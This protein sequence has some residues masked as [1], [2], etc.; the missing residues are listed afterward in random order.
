MKARILI[1]EDDEDMREGLLE[2]LEDYDY[3]VRAAA[4][5]DEGLKLALTYPF[6]LVIH[7]VRMPQMDGLEALARIREIQPQVKALVITGYAD[8][9]APTRAIRQRAFDYLYKPFQLP[10]LLQALENALASAQLQQRNSSWMRKL[11]EG[12]ASLFKRRSAQRWAELEEL[13]QEVY[14]AFFVGVR[15]RRLDQRSALEVWAQLEPAEQALGLG[16]EE[17][18]EQLEHQYR[19]ILA[20]IRALDRGASPPPLPRA[21]RPVDGATFGRFYKRIYEG[22]LSLS[23]VAMGAFLRNIDRVT[24]LQFPELLELQHR[25][26]G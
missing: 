22:G 5:G 16:R 23:E 14:Q 18:L 25:T 20:F 13:R 3:Q 11:S 1:L 24:L 2:A 12:F 26:W 4:T 17:S 10:S 7:D 19:Y 8:Q 9:D 21:S 6:D 15:S